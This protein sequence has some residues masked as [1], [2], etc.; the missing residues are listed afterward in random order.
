MTTPVQVAVAAIVNSENEVLTSFRPEHVHQGGLWEFP[1]GKVE[2][3]ES[4]EQAL[5]REIDEELKFVIHSTRPLIT[6]EHC[7][8]DKTVCLHVWRVD[9]FSSRENNIVDAM[10]GAEGQALKWQPI[11]TLC[12]DDFPA[13][14]KAIITALQLPDKYQITGQFASLNEFEQR[15]LQAIKN[16]V[17]LIQLRLKQDWVKKNYLLARDVCTLARYLSQKH[18]VQLML[19]LPE[20][21]LVIQMKTDYQNLGIHF[22]GV[23]LASLD[24]DA[25]RKF[26]GF[27]YLAASCHN[28]E[29]ILMAQNLGMDFV[30]VS[31]V[32]KTL[33]HVNAQPLG[34]N[35][36][37]S[38]TATSKLPVYA[39]G[40]INEQDLEK[41][42]QCGAQ[43]IAGIRFNW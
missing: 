31:P 25:I 32:Q 43:G 6:L 39:L 35:A 27:R 17:S 10:T 23:H 15:F 24:Q 21:L 9:D 22:T 1:G 42:W 11:D 5:H 8:P 36:F 33:S 37:S 18:A 26:Q 3:G 2:K 41:A 19:N 40:G 28:E 7:Y 34:W 20:E 29:E 38:M 13:A 16:D 4:I 12:V 30:V 14:D